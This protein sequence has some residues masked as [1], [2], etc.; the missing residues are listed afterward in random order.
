VQIPD[1][2]PQPGQLQGTEIGGRAG[3]LDRRQPAPG[4]GLRPR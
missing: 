3:G 4:R 1:R 2:I